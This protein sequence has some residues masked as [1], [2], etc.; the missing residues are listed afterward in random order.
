M[1]SGDGEVMR[2][3]DGS[4]KERVGTGDARFAQN[5]WP[6]GVVSDWETV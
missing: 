1:R 6:G 4:T 3:S 5:P 2:P